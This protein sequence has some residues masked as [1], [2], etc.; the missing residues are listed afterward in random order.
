MSERPHGNPGDF[1]WGS[2]ATWESRVDIHW[3]P[4]ND[5]RTHVQSKKCWCEPLESWGCEWF[6]NSADEREYYEEG[7]RK[8]N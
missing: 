5:I 4:L 6:H 1:G 7:Y 8:S 2:Y 3:I